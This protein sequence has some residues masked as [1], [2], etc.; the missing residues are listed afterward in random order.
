MKCRKATEPRWR[1]PRLERLEKRIAPAGHDTLGTAIPLPVVGGQAQASG[2]LAGANQVDLY[3]VSLQAGDQA[4][5]GISAHAPGSLQSTLRAF[6]SRGGQL[7]LQQ[8]TGSLTFD[9]AVTGVYYVGV[10]SDGDVGYSPTT[11]NSGNGGATSGGYHLT[12]SATFVLVTENPS[13]FT[14][15]TAQTLA[16]NTIVQGTYA[17]G[18][19]EYYQF[20]ATT[21]GDLTAWATSTDATAFQPE[22][23]L[24]GAS[25]QLLIQS[26]G[27]GAGSP[28]AQLNQNLQR[29]T[30][31]LAVSATTDNP[32]GDQSY[33]LDST[34]TPTQPPF[35]AL[36]VGDSPS[37]VAVGD[38]NHDGILDIA[39]ANFEDSSVTVLLGRGDGTFLPAVSYC[40]G[41]EPT[42][43]AVGDFTHDGILDIVTANNGDN[44]VSVLLGRGNGTFL[45]AVSYSVGSYI[46]PG[47]VAVG[48]FT[49]DGILDIATANVYDNSVS[50][51]LGRGDGTF[52]PAVSYRVGEEPTS[53]AVGD[54]TND[55]SLDIATANFEDSSVTV[56]LGRGDGTFLP[57]VSYAVGYSP[58]SLAVGDFDHDGILDIAAAND[59]YNPVTAT[60][61]P[62]M[63]MVL[64][65][66]GDGTFLPAVSYAVGSEPYSLAVGD[67][68]RDG[69]LDIAT[70]NEGDNTVTVLLGRGDGAFLPGV[71][72]PV[73][74]LPDSIAVGDFTNDGSLD[75][76]TANFEDSSVTVLLGR[77]DGT[78]LSSVS[79]AVGSARLF[80]GGGGF[81]P[82]RQP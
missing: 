62:G 7:P 29:G 18:K 81:Q 27:G 42:S 37:S 78:F 57:A 54:F 9:A 79:N 71:S 73:G 65:G 72:Y 15:Q 35:Q 43:I 38:F 31:Y 49:N 63:V 10:S 66:R 82:R 45:H 4:A 59:A 50:V 1:I 8:S 40:V 2:V 44:T 34:F 22:L 11:A 39:T 70:A 26:D 17:A 68:N 6:D 56:L 51:L 25:G 58:S 77:G 52:L 19:T 55:G 36:S 28:S 80:P 61:G 14:L 5:L 64:L 53:I 21:T 13:N 32:P 16:A 74:S 60:Y 67:F 75:I 41:E 69:S 23:A 3:A 46:Y 76:A 12:L 24:Y 48:D 20:T 47:S 30:Y 33:G